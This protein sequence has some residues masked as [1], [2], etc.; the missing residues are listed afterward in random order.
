MKGT[1][2]PDLSTEGAVS[3]L[4]GSSHGDLRSNPVR[5]VLRVTG[6]RVPVP[7]LNRRHP[8]GMPFVERIWS[9]LR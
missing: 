4:A 3:C 7:P 6:R 1:F 5:G 2:T 9:H 8:E